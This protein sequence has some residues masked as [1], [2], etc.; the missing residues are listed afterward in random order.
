MHLGDL[1]K[2]MPGI[3]PEWGTSLCHAA[4]VCLE[5][6]AHVSGVQMDITGTL[7]VRS[8]T[9]TWPQT[10]DQIR[11][12]FADLQD[13]T[14]L[15]ACGIAALLIEEHTELTVFERSKKGPGFDYWLAPKGTD[16][17]LFQNK[18]R[19]EVS[20]LLDGKEPAFNARMRQKLA[21]LERGGV[22]LLGY[23]VV[24]HFARPETRALAVAP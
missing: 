4:S 16:D 17:P 15:G 23:G 20:G 14:E 1:N 19:L 21:Q 6:R 18:Q 22:K 24:V 13:A 2:G 12:T 3:T 8:V 11:R 9:L 10:N 5:D 7:S